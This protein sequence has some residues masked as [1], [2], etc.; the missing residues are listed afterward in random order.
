MARYLAG[1]VIRMKREALNISRE[2]LCEMLSNRAE[3]EVCGVQTLYRIENGKT[4]IKTGMFEKIMEC[5]GQVSERN[6]T[7]ILVPAEKRR[8]LNL[9]TDI[10][11]YIIYKEFQKARETL[12]LLESEI[13]PGYIRSQ[14]YLMEVKATLA[15]EQKEISPEEYIKILFNALRCT[16][17]DLD[18]IDLAGWPY[19]NE[20]F[21]ILFN[22]AKAYD[23][24]KWRDKEE[25]LLL[26]MKASVEH[27][28]MED[29]F[30][31][32]WHST[33]LRQLSE[34]MCLT[35]QHKRSM[36]YCEL[37]I[38]ELK[39]QNLIDLI[40]NFMYDIVWNKEQ[41]IRKGIFP[42][43][44]IP[45]DKK[46]KKDQTFAEKR[47]ILI[48]QERELCKEMLIQAYY[49]SINPREHETT[50]RIKMLGER[51]YPDRFKSLP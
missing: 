34:L 31:A 29:D 16:I 46:N 20:E 32:V 49:L 45:E 35:N 25:E 30:Y 47:G 9:K 23:A 14:Q 41:M 19:N 13:Y 39:N 10:Y 24:M 21:Q 36:E 40:C 26:K 5:M 48:S 50:K 6:Y 7:T 22:I 17:P 2:K 42:Y 44:K 38:E 51:L 4:S 37:G 43:E 27:R 1:R 18:R 11:T 33:I 8:Y 12:E 3:K 28:Y 15:Y